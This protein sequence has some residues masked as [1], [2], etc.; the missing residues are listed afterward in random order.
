[1]P[2][3]GQ[4][5]RLYFRFTNS[6]ARELQLRNQPSTKVGNHAQSCAGR[7]YRNLTASSRVA[8]DRSGRSR[9]SS[10][11]RRKLSEEVFVRLSNGIR[12]HVTKQGPDHGP[13]LLLINGFPDSGFSFSQILPLLPSDLR[14]VVPD[15]RGFGES[16]RPASGYSMTD[17]ALDVLTLLDDLRVPSATLLGHSMG[18]FVA[19]RTAE[20]APSRVDTLV[21]VGTAAT[22]RNDVVRSLA[23][24]AEDFVDPIDPA[25]VR[26]FQLS[27]TFRAVPASFMDRLIAESL[28][29]PAR[30]WKAVLAGL[31]AY[32]IPQKPPRCPTYVIGGA[33]DAV[34]SRAEQEAL[35]ALIPE[36]TFR[37]IEGLGHS[38]QWE[39]P[40]LFT[41]L[42][43][44]I[45]FS[46]GASVRQAVS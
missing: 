44:E 12:L 31:L 27:T 41:T 18:S 4:E 33:E 36:A 1:M 46:H 25:F 10:F 2:H 45:P 28:K 20:L 23:R 37:I 19:R 30:V 7:G 21:L 11:L 39:D 34:F 3:R 15:L 16:D 6:L 38:P 9:V 14:V 17:L 43:R 35:G 5:S 24:D 13:V 42:L 32:E 29:L 26:E 8:Q 40:E 22:P